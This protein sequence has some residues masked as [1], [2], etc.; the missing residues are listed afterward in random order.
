MSLNSFLSPWL[1]NNCAKFR[2]EW[3]G[4]FKNPPKVKFTARNFTT[5]K[6]AGPYNV[7]ISCA[8]QGIPNKLTTRF[9]D[10]ALNVFIAKY[11]F[12]C[13]HQL[14]VAHL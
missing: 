9:P 1:I 12:K 2:K 10:R 6:D 8:W 3:I 5:A 13:W 7:A 11:L 4:R 14:L